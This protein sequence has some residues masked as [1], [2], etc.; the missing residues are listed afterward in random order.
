MSIY[1]FRYNPCIFDK[2]TRNGFF[3]QKRMEKTGKNQ[4]GKRD[5]LFVP[6]KKSKKNCEKAQY[7]FF[8]ILTFCYQI[9]YYLSKR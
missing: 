8:T 6:S 1:F 4:Q 2:I 5:V 9:L 7:R 3:R